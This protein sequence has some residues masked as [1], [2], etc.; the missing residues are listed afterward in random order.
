VFDET[1]GSQREQVNLD[2]LDEEE[3]PTTALRNMEIGI[4]D[5][6]NR[7]KNKINIHPLHR[8]NPLL[9]MTNMTF[10]KIAMIKGSS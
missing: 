1:N 3:A 9:K 7:H 6:R 5:H 10:K 8:L 4:C 2:D